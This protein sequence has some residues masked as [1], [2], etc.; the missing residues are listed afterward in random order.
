MM[1]T[2]WFI[3]LILSNALLLVAARLFVSN[4]E[5]WVK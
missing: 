3:T 5:H 2:L 1:L 4:P